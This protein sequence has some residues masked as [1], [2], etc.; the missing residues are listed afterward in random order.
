MDFSFVRVR[1]L[2]YFFNGVQYQISVHFEDT[3]YAE[4]MFLS[5]NQLYQSD[6]P[7]RKNEE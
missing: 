7:T 5:W 1:V 2:K 6:N 3:A 4:I